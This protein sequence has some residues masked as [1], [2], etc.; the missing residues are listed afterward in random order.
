MPGWS[1]RIGAHRRVTERRTD[2]AWNHALIGAEYS[3]VISLEINLSK[4]ADSEWGSRRY[5]DVTLLEG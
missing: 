3:P 1:S 2:E 5:L 4:T